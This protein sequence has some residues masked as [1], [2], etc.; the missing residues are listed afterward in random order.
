MLLK[1]MEAEGLVRRD[2]DPTDARAKLLFLTPAGAALA[3]KTMKVQGEVVSAMAAA[4]TAK[5]LDLVE[6][7]MAPAC[8]VLE[9]M[10]GGSRDRNR[11]GSA[12]V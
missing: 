7:L 8:E 4:L 12:I 9:A 2:A 3:R 11:P 5:E 1:Q 10:L 6:R